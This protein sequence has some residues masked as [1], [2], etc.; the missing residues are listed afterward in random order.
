METAM[1]HSIETLTQAQ[2]AAITYLHSRRSPQSR[3]ILRTACRKV[4]EYCGQRGYTD[5]QTTAAVRDMLDVY[6]LEA[7]AS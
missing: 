7:N 1:I 5:E 6:A 3:R 2:E 4:R